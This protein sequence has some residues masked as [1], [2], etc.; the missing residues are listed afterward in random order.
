MAPALPSNSTDSPTPARVRLATTRW[1]IDFLIVAATCISL[2]A[3]CLVWSPEKLMWEDEILTQMMLRDFSIWHMI[4]AV[5]GGA[6]S[7][8]P[9][10]HLLG[11]GWIALWGSDPLSLR[12]F[13]SVGMCAAFVILWI[14]LR[15][16]FGRTASALGA[17]PVF[18]MSATLM[19]QNVE[20]RFYGLFLALTALAVFMTMKLAVD[21]RP[22]RSRL[23]A[24]ALATAALVLT[25]LYGG[26]YSVLLCGGLVASDFR[27]GR[28][29]PASYASYAA[30]WLAFLPWVPPFLQQ[31][32]MTQ[33]KSWIPMPTLHDLAASYQFGIRW[34]P[35]V[36]LIA[37]LLPP[38]ARAGWRLGAESSD[39]RLRAENRS[40]LLFV[41][42]AL[43]VAPVISF[44]V[45]LAVTPVFWHR[46]LMP[47][48]FS[49]AIAIAWIATPGIVPPSSAKDT[50]ATVVRTAARAALAVIVAGFVVLPYH[51]GVVAPRIPDWRQQFEALTV[52]GQP[53]SSL[54]VGV[55]GVETYLQYRYY[56][57]VEGL[58]TYLL[59]SVVADAPGS[60]PRAI[61]EHNLFRIY[62]RFGYLG[63]PG[64]AD[65]D[66]TQPFLCEHE[67]FV[68]LDDP[69]LG[70]FETHVAPSAQWMSRAIA[71]LGRDTARYVWRREGLTLPGCGNP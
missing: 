24:N 8:P 34:L 29:R 68:I 63:A 4:S 6:D 30:G 17:L 70:W 32:G 52:N 3:A 48:S 31:S 64:S 25:H 23:I 46:Y 20:V 57:P 71:G 45:S 66:F 5:A 65:A 47:A 33:G 67:R 50:A 54:P 40:A 51:S 15:Q 2:I 14:T 21:D 7:A 61:V 35:L 42:A 9:L 19:T 13:S 39:Q 59:D 37:L 38:V 49:W 12:L 44:I 62:Q 16:A 1:G 18:G 22:T 58:Y 56:T 43:L 53:V 41:A 26:L 28:W 60:D 36:I 69:T 10:Y 55:E 27:R 11:R